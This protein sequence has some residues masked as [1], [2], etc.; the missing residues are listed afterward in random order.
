[1]GEPLDSR[2]RRAEPQGLRVGFCDRW[3]ASSK[4]RQRVWTWMGTVA[5]FGR[6]EMKLLLSQ[7]MRVYFPWK[8]SFPS[9]EELWLTTWGTI[10][11]TGIKQTRVSYG[12]SQ[13][14]VPTWSLLCFSSKWSNSLRANLDRAKTM[15]IMLVSDCLPQRLWLN[16]DIHSPSCLFRIIIKR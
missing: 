1:M 4:G 6:E 3:R 15:N 11:L 14:N 7:S 9:Q 13:K 8:A 10:F 16:V 12:F 2:G 5:T